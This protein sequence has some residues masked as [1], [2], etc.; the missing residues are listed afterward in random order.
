M[1]SA[2]PNDVFNSVSRITEF[3][4]SVLNSSCKL[5]VYFG[6]SFGRGVLYISVIAFVQIRL[7]AVLEAFVIDSQVTVSYNYEQKHN[8]PPRF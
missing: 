3:R 1:Y 4:F 8:Y 7:N 6:Q 2:E 5:F